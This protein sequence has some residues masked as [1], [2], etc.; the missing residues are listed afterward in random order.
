MISS[1]RPSLK[2]SCSGSLLMFTKGNTAIDF[3]VISP[4]SE[5]GLSIGDAGLCPSK[6]FILEIISF[7]ALAKLLT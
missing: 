5:M 1:V 2:N 3:M 6:F 7:A 4:L